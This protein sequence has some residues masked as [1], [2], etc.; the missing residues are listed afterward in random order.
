MRLLGREE[1]PNRQPTI[2]ENIADLQG[3]IARGEDLYTADELRL[4]KS[5]L[6]DYEHMLRRLMEP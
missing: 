1:S 6:A 5:K 2:L 4:L 3:E